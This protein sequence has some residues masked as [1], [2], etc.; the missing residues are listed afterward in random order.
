MENFRW[1]INTPKEELEKYGFYCEYGTWH[2][3]LCVDTD[4]HQFEVMGVLIL[5]SGGS[6]DA[7]GRTD[8]DLIKQL[9]QDGIIYEVK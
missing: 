3:D 1:N 4:E 8:D 6:I 9:I 2:Y 7:A 5:N